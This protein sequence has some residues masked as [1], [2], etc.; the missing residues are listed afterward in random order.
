MNFKRKR[1][2]GGARPLPGWPLGAGI[3]V[4]VCLAGAAGG[5]G[6]EVER[7]DLGTVV[8]EVPVVAGSET[9]YPIPDL[10]APS[11]EVPSSDV[12]AKAPRPAP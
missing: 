5:C 11:P 9:P 10:D 1:G 8:F 4:A 7:E 2:R 6:P 12:R 3:R